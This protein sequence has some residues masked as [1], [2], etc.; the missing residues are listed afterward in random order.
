VRPRLQAVRPGGLGQ[1]VRM[2]GGQFAA[3]FQTKLCAMLWRS[4]DIAVRSSN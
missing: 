4:Y 3:S 2:L 1:Q